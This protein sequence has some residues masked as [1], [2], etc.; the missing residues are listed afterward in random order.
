MYLLL[1][2]ND[3]IYVGATIRRLELESDLTAQKSLLYVLA[4]AVN[5]EADAEISKYAN[6]RTKPEAARAVA[7]DFA[8]AF[9]SA[10]GGG[11][12]ARLA[13]LARQRREQL[14]IVSDEAIF[15][16]QRLTEEMR[17]SQRQ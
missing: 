17:Q 11:Q 4:Y 15:E 5:A 1:P 14:K 2:L 6:D 7:V 3:G 16:I 9:P 13:T 10:K 8:K 12:N